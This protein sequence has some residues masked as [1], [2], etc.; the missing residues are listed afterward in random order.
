MGI[1]KIDIEN[2]GEKRL[3]VYRIRQRMFCYYPS[4]IDVALD[5]M[6]GEQE[7]VKSGKSHVLSFSGYP[8][9][10]QHIADGVNFYEQHQ[11]MFKISRENG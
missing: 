10:Y 4:D 3:V 11:K 1:F 2:Y 5:D 9:L 7:D 8:I 6:L